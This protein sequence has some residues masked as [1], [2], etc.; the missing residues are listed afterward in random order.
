MD[1]EILIQRSVKSLRK[2]SEQ[3]ISEVADFIDFIS[4]KY[5]NECDLQSNITKMVEDSNSFEFLKDEEDLY[6]ESDLKERY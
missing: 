3:R 2:L 4:E 5:S 6:T 1:K